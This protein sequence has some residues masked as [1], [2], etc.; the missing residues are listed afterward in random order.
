M[1][2][3][4]DQISIRSSR[5]GTWWLSFVL[6]FCF[7]WSRFSLPNLTWASSRDNWFWFLLS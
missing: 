1:M 4:T 2:S 5:I 6:D 3:Y 7:Y